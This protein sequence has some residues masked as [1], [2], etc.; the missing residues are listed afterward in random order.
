MLHDERP[1]RCS[2]LCDYV[3][4]THVIGRHLPRPVNGGYMN[5]CILP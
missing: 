1:W 4:D 2:L 3:T 5:A